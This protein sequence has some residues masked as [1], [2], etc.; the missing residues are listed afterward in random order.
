MVEHRPT[1]IA[2]FEFHTIPTMSHFPHLLS[3]VTLGSVPMRNRVVMSALT[4]DRSTPTNV[5][6]EVC[7]RPT[8][9]RNE[10]QSTVNAQAPTRVLQAARE[11]RC[12]PHCIRGYFGVTTRV[13]SD[14][15]IRDL[16]E[17]PRRQH[18]MAKCPWDMVGRSYPCM[19]KDNGCCAF[20]GWKNFLSGAYCFT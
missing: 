17:R 20:G 4:R 16:C 11:R 10:T 14:T 2:V 8:R 7:I 6:N 9:G 19:A 12:W 3:P 5:P 13:S 15:H 1:S 18:G